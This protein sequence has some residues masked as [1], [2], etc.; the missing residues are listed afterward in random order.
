MKCF[1]EYNFFYD[2]SLVLIASKKDLNDGF[3]QALL[4]A[5][6]EL[7]SDYDFVIFESGLEFVL[8]RYKR[9]VKDEEGDF[10]L[11]FSGVNLVFAVRALEIFAENSLENSNILAFTE[12]IKRWEFGISKY[13]N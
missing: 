2:S 3:F 12:E 1:F 9:R 6:F 7:S 5:D 10:K 4:S 13:Q 8:N 11:R